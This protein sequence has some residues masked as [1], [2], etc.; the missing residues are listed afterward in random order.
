[1]SKLHPLLRI[2]IALLL[3]IFISFCVI[4]LADSINVALYPSKHISPTFDEMQKEINTLPWTAFLIVSIGY[5]LSSFF[6]AYIAARISP[7]KYKLVVAMTI[8]FFLLLGGIVY[9]IAFPNP[10]WLSITSCISFMVF[11]YAGG[12]LAGG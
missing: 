1:M 9:S 4:L 2:I 3:G 7:E 6:G 5:M 11:A 10:L 12:K 8:G